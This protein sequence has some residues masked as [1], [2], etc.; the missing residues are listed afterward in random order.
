MAVPGRENRSP[1]NGELPLT[2]ETRNSSHFIEN[3]GRANCGETRET[4]LAIEM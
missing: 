3:I 2:K 4:G 1:A